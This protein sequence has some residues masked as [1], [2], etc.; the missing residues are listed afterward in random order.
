[1][2]RLR[3]FTLEVENVVRKETK[4]MNNKRKKPPMFEEET[5]TIV[6]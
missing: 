3:F 6:L 2:M 4:V 5:Q 1:V